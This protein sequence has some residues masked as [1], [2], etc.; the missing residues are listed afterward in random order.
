MYIIFTI[1]R[2]GSSLLVHILNKFKDVTFA[3]EIYTLDLFARINRGDKRIPIDAFNVFN[4]KNIILNGRYSNSSVY[5]PQRTNYAINMKRKEKFLEKFHKIDNVEKRLKFIM[6]IDKISGCKILTKSEGIKNFLKMDNL[7][8]IKL[9]LLV[10][11]DI[12]AQLKSMRRARFIKSN[13][14]EPNIEYENNEYKKIYNDNKSRIYYLTYEDIVNRRN[15]FKGLF[16]FMKLDYD[17]KKV[18]SGLSIV[19]SYASSLIN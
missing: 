6:P 15:R 9:I 16:K 13:G 2:T 3:G 1:G 4:N 17:E 11:E 5:F 18:I 14:R 7:K 8:D 12:K 19:C 10:R